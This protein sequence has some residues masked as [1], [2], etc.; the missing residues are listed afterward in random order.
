MLTLDSE[1]SEI[2]KG[3]FAQLK[4]RVISVRVSGLTWHNQNVLVV[5]EEGDHQFLWAYS[6]DFK[7]RTLLLKKDLS[8]ESS[9]FDDKSFFDFIET[10]SQLI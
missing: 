4:G 6:P 1:G 7:E 8:C 9:K 2:L 3:D 5:T 10:G